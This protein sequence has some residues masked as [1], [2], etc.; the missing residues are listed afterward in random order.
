[1]S[2]PTFFAGALPERA[3]KPPQ[4]GQ[5]GGCAPG[6]GLTGVDMALLLVDAEQQRPE[7][8]AAASASWCP[9]AD[10]DVLSGA[11]S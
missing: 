8:L 1:M 4:G 5:R 2:S 6:A 9:A 10:H 11:R 3:E 7:G